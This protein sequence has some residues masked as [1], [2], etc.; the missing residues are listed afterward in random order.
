[1]VS[2]T[3]SRD[4]E[5]PDTPNPLDSEFASLRDAAL[6]SLPEMERKLEECR[7]RCRQLEDEMR[8]TRLIASFGASEPGSTPGPRTLH[9]AMKLV[10]EEHQSGL[11]PA[12][13]TD[14]IYRRALYRT[15]A[16]ATPTINQIHSRV[17]G[18]PSLFVRDEGRIRLRQPDE[19]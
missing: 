10:L 4:R 3:S 5:G 2:D 13:L 19:H 16:G 18:Y 11:R 6:A 15:R 9:D 7:A 8:L 1:M 17:S 12:E 14:E